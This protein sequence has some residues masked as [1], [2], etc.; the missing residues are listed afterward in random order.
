MTEKIA[1][2]TFGQKAQNFLFPGNKK[3]KIIV[4]LQ[5]GREILIDSRGIVALALDEL[6]ATLVDVE[7]QSAEVL[8]GY[9]SP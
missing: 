7:E 9:L 6:G 4:R 8:I 5:D 2:K 1:D 3:T